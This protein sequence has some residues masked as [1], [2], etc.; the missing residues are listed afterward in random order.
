MIPRA[1]RVIPAQFPMNEAITISGMGDTAITATNEARQ[2]R[3]RLL[4]WAKTI[5]TV[6][7]TGTATVAA[8]ALKSIKTLTRM[9]EDG[10]TSAKGPVIELGRKIDALAKE[11][12]T[13]LETEATRISRQLGVWQAEQNRI[14]EEAR[15]AA[16]REEQRIRDEANR[17]AKEA[18]DKAAAIQAELERKQAKART[19]A[20]A[21]DYAREAVGKNLL[22]EQEQ[23]RRDLATQQ[24]IVETRV[25]AAAV[26]PPKLAGVATRTEIAFEITNIVALYEVAP[27]LVKM[28]PNVAALKAALKGLQPGQHLPGV[29][30]WEEAK[31]HV[32]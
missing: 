9:I 17:A 22:A 30:H 24:A 11:L 10:R 27:Y 18:A 12:C 4:T 6:N 14:A 19:D 21:E 1:G 31:T 5:S 13:S 28:E 32:R 2:E 16:W 29:K 26:A 23:E 25:A 8:D 7:S 15:Q 3:D 20:K